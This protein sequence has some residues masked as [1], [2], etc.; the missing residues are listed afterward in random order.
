VKGP[1]RSQNYQLFRAFNTRKWNQNWCPG[2]HG[3]KGSY[4]LW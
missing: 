2:W 1:N 3:K 4:E